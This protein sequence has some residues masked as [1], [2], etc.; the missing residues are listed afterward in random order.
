V[1][2]FDL[3]PEDDSDDGAPLKIE[4]GV[5]YMFA[6][7]KTLEFIYNYINYTWKIGAETITARAYLDDIDDVSLFAEV[8]GVSTFMTPDKLEAAEFQST[9]RYLQRRYRVIKTFGGDGTY[10]VAYKR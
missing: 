7:P 1:K 8:D 9:L 4:H 3:P 2:S 10:V 6:S 5:D